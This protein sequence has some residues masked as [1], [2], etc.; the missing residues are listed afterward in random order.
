MHHGLGSMRG[1][2]SPEKVPLLESARGGS[3]AIGISFLCACVGS[4][5]MEYLFCRLQGKC[6]LSQPPWTAE[7]GTSP[8]LLRVP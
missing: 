4:Q 1:P 6:K 7:V 5:V 3:I 8:S 2:A